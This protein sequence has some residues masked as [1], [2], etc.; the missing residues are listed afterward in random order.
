[1]LII[2][3]NE[4]LKFIFGKLIE[5]KRKEDYKEQLVFNIGFNKTTGTRKWTKNKIRKVKK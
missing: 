4:E 2:E 1:L 3:T 5:L